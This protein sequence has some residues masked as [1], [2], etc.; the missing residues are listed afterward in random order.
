MSAFDH[1]LPAEVRK[2]LGRRLGG[3]RKNLLHPDSAR[4]DGAKG[5]RTTVERNPGM[6]TSGHGRRLA[7]SKRSKWLVALGAQLLNDREI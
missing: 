3:Y 2:A 6:R 4:I 5:G 7:P 1:Q